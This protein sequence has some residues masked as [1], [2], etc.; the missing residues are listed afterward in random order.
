MGI[1]ALR[2][3]FRKRTKISDRIKVRDLHQQ[4][5]SASFLARSVNTA[6]R[7]CLSRRCNTFNHGRGGLSSPPHP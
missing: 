5:L 1:K 7:A 3:D 6:W 2:E 4:L